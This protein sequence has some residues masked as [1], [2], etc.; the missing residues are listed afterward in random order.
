MT[1]AT[2]RLTGATDQVRTTLDAVGSQPAGFIAIEQYDDTAGLS[3]NRFGI[4]R[5]TTA[6]S[7]P[8]S[9]AGIRGRS[10]TFTTPTHRLRQTIGNAP[11]CS[12]AELESVLGSRPR[13][14]ES[15]ILRWSDM[16]R[17]ELVTARPQAEHRS[18]SQFGLR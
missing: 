3:G 4:E 12:S 2:P 14:F 11:E 18:W 1:R 8:V 13:G 10:L 15:R 7:I 17:W 6:V 5:V 9:V 16:G